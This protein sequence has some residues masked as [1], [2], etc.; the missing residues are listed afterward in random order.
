MESWSAARQSEKAS[1][2][3]ADDFCEA[4]HRYMKDGRYHDARLSGQQ[5]LAADSTHPDALHLMGM[6]SL[7]AKQYDEAIEWISLSIRQEPK[8]AY[9]ISLGTA[10]LQSG[11]HEDALK[12]FDK[13]VQLK[14][15]DAASWRRLGDALVDVGR[16]AD[17]VLCLKHA[18]SLDP[19]NRGEAERC[20]ILL[21]RLGRFEDALHCFDLCDQLC[22]DRASTLYMRGRCLLDL[23]RVDEGLSLCQ[24]AHALNPA[25]AEISNAIGLAFQSLGQHGKAVEAFDKAIGSRSNFVEALNNKAISLGHFRRWE[26]AIQLLDRA[27]GLSPSY[28]PALANKAIYLSALHR[29]DEAFEVYGRIRTIDPK[30]GDA[31]WNLAVLHLL[32][33]NFIDGWQAAEARW[34]SQARSRTYPNFSEPRWRGEEPIKGKTVLVYAD[35][36]LGDTIQFARYL[37]MIVARGARVILVVEGAARPLL[38]S[39]PGL[40]ECLPKPLARPVVFDFH[41]PMS[42]LP[43]IFR[44]RLDTIPSGLSYLPPLPQNRVNAWQDRLAPRKQMRIGLAWSGSPH[45]VNDHNRSIPLGAF[46]PLLD[47]GATFV[48]LQKDPRPADKAILTE[49]GDILDLTDGFSDLVETGALISCLDLVITVDTSIAHLAGSLGKPTWI[50]LPYTP[51]YRWLLD[52]DDSPWYPT[53]RLFRQDRDCDYISVLDRVRTAL[54]D[55]VPRLRQA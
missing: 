48:S 11:R 42:S 50:L 4:G 22:P 55:L 9:L 31:G 7:Q 53:V 29:F 15:D 46:L 28:M 6:L 52:R 36:G 41:C 16:P 25:D 23:K 35:E 3:S 21:H 38:A 26:E 30:N 24:R 54:T 17:G 18:L 8:P 27:L 49:R 44:T 14:P 10:L 34:Q 33:G 5:A 1:S 45:H 13:A 12:A 51:D 20:G 37:P 19:Q 32:T 2:G 43:L 39:L 40:C 47:A